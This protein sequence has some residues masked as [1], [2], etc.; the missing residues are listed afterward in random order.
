MLTRTQ[1][2]ARNIA[3]KFA[4]AKGVRVVERGTRVGL[5]GHRERAPA[6]L[7]TIS[8]NAQPPQF[9][10]GLHAL[11]ATTDRRN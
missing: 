9:K 2:A 10:T 11:L 4:A 7:P 5:C 1:I 6:D 8:L 3:R